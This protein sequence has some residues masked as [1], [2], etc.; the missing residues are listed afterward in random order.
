M[1][2][3]LHQPHIQVVFGQQRTLGSSNSRH[4]VRL[5]AGVRVRGVVGTAVGRLARGF[6]AVDRGVG[7]VAVEGSGLARTLDGVAVV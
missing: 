2:T 5:T 7:R 3:H 4:D 6:G 1:G